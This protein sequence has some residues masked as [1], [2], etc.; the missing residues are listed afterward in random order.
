MTL[1]ARR[2]RRM[3][4]TWKKEASVAAQLVFVACVLSYAMRPMTYTYADPDTAS[5]PGTPTALRSCLLD[6]RD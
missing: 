3:A 5:G 1:V 2:L 4:V 6:V